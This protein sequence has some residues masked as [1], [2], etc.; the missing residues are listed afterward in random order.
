[1]EEKNFIQRYF[2]RFVHTANTQVQDRQFIMVRPC[3][4]DHNVDVGANLCVRPICVILNLYY[5]IDNEG[6][7]TGLPLLYG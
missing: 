7:H 2:T 1:M 3:D 6:K 5:R 4:D